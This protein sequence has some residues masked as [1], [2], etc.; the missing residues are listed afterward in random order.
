MA[1]QPLLSEISQKLNVTQ[2]AKHRFAHKLAPDFNIFH[3]LRNDELGLSKCIAD[4]LDPQGPHGQKSL[5]LESFLEK[6]E[7][8]NHLDV[9]K[10]V[11]VELEHQTLKGRRIDILLRFENGLIGIENKP[12]AADQYRQMEDYRRYLEQMCSNNQ[13]W[14]LVF[15]SERDPSDESISSDALAKLAKDKHYIQLDFKSVE[16]WLQETSAK[17]EAPRVR[18]FVEELAAYVKQQINGELDMT[19]E[20]EIIS[21]VNASDENIAAAANIVKSWDSITSKLMAHFEKKLS[22][23]F[24]DSSKVKY[25]AESNAFLSSGKAHSGF[26]VECPNDRQFQDLWIGFRFDRPNF[27]DF[28]V[29]VAIIDRDQSKVADRAHAIHSAMR[30]EFG[31]GSSNQYYDWWLWGDSPGLKLGNGFRNW[32]LSSEPWVAIKNEKLVDKIVD[33]SERVFKTLENSAS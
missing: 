22:P 30:Q 6:I 2:E 21:I 8:V 32:A 23:G 14:T 29:G 17:V 15:L 5:F 25:K 10:P 12:W 11:Q 27:H 7:K 26:L 16:D 31:G 1:F 33:V 20:S 18:T 3:Y 19:E 13:S 9:E 24:K 4:L 28:F